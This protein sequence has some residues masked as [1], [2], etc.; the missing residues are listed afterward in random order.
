[1][2]AG[3]RAVEAAELRPGARGAEVGGVWVHSVRLP[4]L[5]AHQ[6]VLFGN[7]GE[8]L[9]IRHDTTDRA[10]FVPGVLIAIR[11]VATLDPGVTVGLESLLGL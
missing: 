8:V 7:H 2:P 3:S 1:R 6:E 9:T 5:L 4:G 11:S 10:A